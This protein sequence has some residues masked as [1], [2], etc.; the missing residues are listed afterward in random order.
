M[1]VSAVRKNAARWL[2]LRR[3]A[4]RKFLNPS[5]DLHTAD[6]KERRLCVSAMA[7]KAITVEPRVANSAAIE[8]VADPRPEFGSVLVETRA[9]GVCGT[10]SE[11]LLGE[12]GWPPTGEK[13]LI[14]GH[15]SL[16]RVLEAPAACG[17]AAGDFV[18]GIVRR[19]DPVP[20]SNCA[21]GE[22][23]MCRNSLYTEHGIKELHGFACERFR[24]DPERLVKVDQG[25]GTLGV[26]LEPASILAKAWEHIEHIGRRSRW[27]PRR[28]LVTGAGPIGLLAALMSRQRGLEADVLDRVT[29]GPKPELVRAL[30]ASYYI[31]IAAA[32]ARA[33]DVAIE[34]TGAGALVFEVMKGTTPSG[35]VCL[36]GVSSGGRK[37]SLDVGSLNQTMVLE[38]D[39]VF[40]TVNANRR[41]YEAAALALAQ[42]DRE[43]LAGLITRKVSLDRWQDAF[44]RKPQDVKVVIEFPSNA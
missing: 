44:N 5:V 11:I 40:G 12:Y 15:E 20:C 22:W 7:M 18:V 10:D 28:V 17:L 16:G 3:N 41:H 30:G 6:S 21:V 27:E 14:L 36:T 38:N 37:L 8:D 42:A 23:D 31:D 4:W 43:W 33:P 29:D 2:A 19:P 39:V 32:L 34:C 1:N 13:R 9:I 24:S 25:L 35:I 26:L